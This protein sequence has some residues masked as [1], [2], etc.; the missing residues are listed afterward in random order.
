MDAVE[1]Y[2]PELV[3]EVRGI[4][5]GSRL[6]FCQAFFLQVATELELAG[7][8][9]GCSSVG[10]SITVEPILAQNWDQPHESANKQIVLWLQ[11]LDRPDLIMFT[12]AGSVGYIGVN[13][14]GVGLVNNQ[15]Y[16]DPSSTGLTGYFIMRKLLGFG[17]VTSGLG[18][19]SSVETGSTANYL[20]GDALGDIVDIEVG[21]GTF[22][23]IDGRLQQHTN[24]RLIS[25]WQSADRASELLPDSVDRLS[26][27]RHL[28]NGRGSEPDVL[29]ALRDHDG[30]PVSICRHE[31]GG[32]T[33]AASILLRLKQREMLLAYG[34]PCRTDYE[35]YR[36]TTI[37]TPRS[38]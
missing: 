5:E 3:E 28:C 19:L 29:S 23:R 36:F 9:D 35:S 24:H 12:H 16:S 4:A 38:V 26:R 20:L 6:S 8:R 7:A 10:S 31:T 22:R 37:A 33:T 18:W 17:T 13:S 21:D 34:P 1:R 32:L 15:L 27:L 30:Y 25:G 11:P 2:A 14:A